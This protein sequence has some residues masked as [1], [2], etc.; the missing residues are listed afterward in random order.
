MVG[1]FDTGR[2]CHQ[3][4]PFCEGVWVTPNVNAKAHLITV[5]SY[6]C[7]HQFKVSRSGIYRESCL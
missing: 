4:G 2:R 5:F 1:N 6:I 7:D 3:R